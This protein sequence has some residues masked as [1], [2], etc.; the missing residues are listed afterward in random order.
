MKTTPE[1]PA[2]GSRNTVGTVARSPE[3]S[4]AIYRY[5]SAIWQ[6]I[7]ISIYSKNLVKTGYLQIFYI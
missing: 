6:Q 5:N 4:S 7:L 1:L 3:D 2:A